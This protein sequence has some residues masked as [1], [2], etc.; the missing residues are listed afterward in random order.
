[1]RS[2]DI[3][4]EGLKIG[5]NNSPCVVAE[6]S[7]NHNQSIETAL[8]IVDAAADAGCQAIKLQTYRAD[9]MTI[10]SNKPDFLIKG[11]NPDWEGKTLYDLYEKAFTPWEW[12]EELF[13]RAKE[14]GMIAFSTPFDL[15]AVDFLEKLN[16]PAYKIAS[17]ENNWVELIDRVARTKKPIIISTG[18]SDLSIVERAVK[19]A[20]D[21][22]NEQIILLKCTSSYPADPKNSNLATIPALAEKFDVQVGISDHTL[23]IGAS[24]AAVALGATMIEKHLILDRKDESFDSSFS[25]NPDEMKQLVVESERAW[26]SVGQV[27]YG[28]TQGEENSLRFKR[29]I[30]VVEPIKAGET[31]TRK[32]TRV[33]RP[34]YSLEPRLHGEILGKVSK[35]DLEIGDRIDENSF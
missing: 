30:Y 33:I 19:T 20:R 3:N 5:P 35:K 32:N 8:R 28:L 29:S 17:F 18:V 22:G 23:G 31:F 26:Q 11:S 7:C 24:I 27:F 13:K 12:H 15:E 34:G 10:R 9:T 25:M 16:V 21:A 4:I 6:L 2:E 14:R 1:M